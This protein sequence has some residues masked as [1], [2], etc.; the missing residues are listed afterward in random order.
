MEL[1][2]RGSAF[3]SCRS[4]PPRR[5]YHA[6]ATKSGVGKFGENDRTRH[7]QSP[8]IPPEPGHSGRKDGRDLQPSFIPFRHPPPG[9]TLPFGFQFH[10]F[11]THHGLLI[12][13]R[14]AH[15]SREKTCHQRRLGTAVANRAAASSGVKNRILSPLWLGSSLIGH[16]QRSSKIGLC[17]RKHHSVSEVG[18]IVCAFT[19]AT[20]I[21][22][23][24]HRF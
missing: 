14:I 20:V 17:A 18:T 12:F 9:I 19:E 6:Q 16:P 8:T 7:D 4:P 3:G 2:A 23:T 11:I 21:P 10:L 15:H 5:R 1:R 13:S 22:R 24:G